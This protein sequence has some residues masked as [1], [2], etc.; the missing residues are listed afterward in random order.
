MPCRRV[1]HFR[2]I[3][4]DA[5][6]GY[7]WLKPKGPCLPDD[8]TTHDLE[9]KALASAA[10]PPSRFELAGGALGLSRTMLIVTGS[11]AAVIAIFAVVF[12]LWPA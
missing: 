2:P 11:A 5:L 8:I 9:D 4:P 7:A 12:V 3:D 6:I 10:V 1:G